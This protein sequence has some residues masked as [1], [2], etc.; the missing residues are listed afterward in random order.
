MQIKTIFGN[1]AVVLF[2]LGVTTAVFVDIQSDVDRERFS[3]I[4]DSTDT[5]P[6]PLFE[7]HLSDVLPQQTAYVILA[8]MGLTSQLLVMLAF[9]LGAIGFGLQTIDFIGELFTECL[10]AI[11]RLFVLRRHKQETVTP[12]D[13]DEDMGQSVVTRPVAP[14]PPSCPPPRPLIN[15]SQREAVAAS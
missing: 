11:R 5:N 9:A 10:N 2:V 6:D 7:H 13:P 14:I 3:M 12:D 8:A 15:R 1:V 4:L